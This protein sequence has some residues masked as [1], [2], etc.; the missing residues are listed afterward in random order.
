MNEKKEREERQKQAWGIDMCQ[1]EMDVGQSLFS[2]KAK[3]RHTSPSMLGAWGGANGGW[4]LGWA[5]A[6][7]QRLNTRPCHWQSGK[8][9]VKLHLLGGMLGP[10]PEL[11]V[12]K[13]GMGPHWGNVWA[14]RKM[15]EEGGGERVG[16]RGRCV[17]TVCVCACGVMR[18]RCC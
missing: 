11:A 9:N 10:D 15:R 12:S 5:Q 4:E 1:G 7:G 14:S 8:N 18:A 6:V 3:P 16:W 13:G 17:C 2:L